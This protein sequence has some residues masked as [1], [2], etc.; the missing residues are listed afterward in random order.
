MLNQQTIRETHAMRICSMAEYAQQREERRQRSSARNAL[1]CWWI[2]SGTGDRSGAGTAKTRERL[3]G[4]A[5]MEDIDFRA[6][7][8]W[9][10]KWCVR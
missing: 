10:S 3:Q 1:P 5:C 8:V 2:A 6:A 7:Q 9:T 4:P